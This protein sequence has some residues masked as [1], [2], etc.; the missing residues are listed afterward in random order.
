MSPRNMS[1]WMQMS[2][3][4]RNAYDQELKKINMQK[5]MKLISD[6]R[7]EYKGLNKLSGK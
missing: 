1:S 5:K 6:I 7:K 4:D 2:R 3:E